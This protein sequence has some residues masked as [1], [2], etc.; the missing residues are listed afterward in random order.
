M[1]DALKIAELLAGPVTDLIKAIVDKDEEA[2]ERV[3][4]ILPEQ[5]ESGKV[6]A[7]LRAKVQP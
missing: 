6:A 1:S 5:S 7:K 4:Q 2:A 3:R